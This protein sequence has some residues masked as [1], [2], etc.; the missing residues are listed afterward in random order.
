MALKYLSFLE[1]SKNRSAARALPPDPCLYEMIE[2]HHFA[3]HATQSR[4]F[5]SKNF[6]NFQTPSFSKMLVSRLFMGV[7]ESRNVGK[8]NRLFRF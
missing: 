8:Q 7:S 5:L 4:H 3:P 2:L 6:F 1:K